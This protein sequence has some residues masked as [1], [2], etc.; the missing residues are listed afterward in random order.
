MTLKP[1]S[2]EGTNNQIFFFLTR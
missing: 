1:L 2:F